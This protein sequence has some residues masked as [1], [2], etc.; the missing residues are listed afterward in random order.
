MS[1]A[2]CG[3]STE[4]KLRSTKIQTSPG[5]KAAAHRLQ[6]S[7]EREGR[8]RK[9]GDR[10][11]VKHVAEK[12]VD[13]KQDQAD[14]KHRLHAEP[15]HVLRAVLVLL[16]HGLLLLVLLHAGHRR[17]SRAGAVCKN[18]RRR[19][20]LFKLLHCVACAEFDLIFGWNFP[21]DCTSLALSPQQR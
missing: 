7:E 15:L 18:R 12:V 13:D 1:P 8:K 16:H 19:V 3:W 4:P 5:E 2:P 9:L 21:L 20:L 14:K 10:D 6:T 11:A 17:T